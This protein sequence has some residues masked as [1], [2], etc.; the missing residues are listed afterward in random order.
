MD[1]IL[2]KIKAMFRLTNDLRNWQLPKS[3]CL[4]KDGKKSMKLYLNSTK[5]DL[6]NQVLPLISVTYL[7]S[8]FGFI[9]FERESVKRPRKLVVLTRMTQ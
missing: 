5:N 2:A 1:P 7:F 9:S 8:T 4:N 6:I 3:S